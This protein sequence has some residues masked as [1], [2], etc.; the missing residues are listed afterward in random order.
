[1][2][3][4]GVKSSK[5]EA[6][7]AGGL[8]AL[9]AAISYGIL[10]PR[11]GFYRDD[12]YMLWAGQSNLGLSGIIQLFQTDRPLIGWVYALVF[13]YIGANALSWQVYAL[14]LKILTGLTFLWI[15]RL[16]W[17]DKRLE[18]TFAAL[19][20]VLY[21]GFFQQ[22]VAA[23]FAT[24]LMGLNA[25]FISIALT[26]YAI[27]TPNRLLKGTATL[28]A[29][30]LGL[31][32]V[33]LYEATIGLEV[34]RWALVWY[35][36]WQRNV[37]A[38]ER[39]SAS[40][41]IFTETKKA[42]PKEIATA[43]RNP[44]FAMT[45]KALKTLL[46]YL[47]MIA[48]FVVWR[49][50][51]FESVRR[52][53]NVNVLLAD[54]ASNPLYSVSQIFIGYLKDLFE[55]IVSA[56]F[57][58]FYQ[59]TADGRYT[60][61]LSGLGVTLVVLALVAVYLIWFR[62]RYADPQPGDSFSRH[63]LI[64]GL[65]AVAIPS[66]V[67]VVLGRNV[68]FSTQWDRYTT[69]SMFGVALV[70]LGAI[71]YFLRGSARWAVFFSLLFLAVM[72]HYHSAAY[73]ARF[74]DQER[75][76]VWQ[77]SWRAPALQQGTTVIV[78]LPDGYRLAEEYEVWGPVN[79]AY[80]P[81]QPMQVS[82]QIPYDGMLLDL[83]DGKKEFR[84]M[85]NINVKRDYSK[86][87]ILSMPSQNSCVHVIDGQHLT[88]PY[89]EN[90][91][92]KDVAALSR[93]DLIDPSAAPVTPPVSTFGAEPEHG[94]CFYYQKMGLALQAGNFAEAA[95]LAD[96]AAQKG[97]KPSDETEWVPIIVAYANLGQVD[98]ASSAAD[99]I[100]KSVRRYICL[101]QAAMNPW[102]QGY[103]GDLIRSAL[104]GGN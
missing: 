84:T 90:P 68:L 99:E 21:P 100:D 49:L 81:G 1:M 37:I 58:P 22:P 67:I 64:L 44:C 101:Q 35:L 19:L 47:L 34:V 61:F 59:F 20:F 92:I 16:V 86:P 91:R 63:F 52:A 72:T 85:R 104:C 55:T 17:P 94:W 97:L 12:W 23:T 4:N 95:R 78:S 30:A 98:K 10:I 5:T 15:V 74:W 96:E 83:L 7:L 8:I 29:M 41:A 25:A 60:D 43:I 65:I 80:Y 42:G 31:F 69:Q 62:R 76:I 56:W 13:K 28:A 87:L 88:L 48:S 27:K 2:N 77:L 24:D 57:V 38:N 93:I 70:I 53:T 11:L 66:A 36:I 54:Y 79:M 82:G 102:P 33:A 3:Q 75:N 18:T 26:I 14:L 9:T 6:W 45:G 39:T 50:F 32:Y 89:Y 40:E 46:P 51:F 71:L 103:N 73:Y